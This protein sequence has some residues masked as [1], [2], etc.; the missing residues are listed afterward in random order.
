MDPKEHQPK[1]PAPKMWETEKVSV[2]KQSLANERRISKKL[3]FKL[4]PGSGN[5]AWPS[6]KGDGTTDE[7]VFELKETIRDRFTITPEVLAKLWREAGTAGKHPALV[8]SM[9]G[10]EE[11]VPKE[12]VAVPMEV[13]NEM[14]EQK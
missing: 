9:Y 10:L 11:P 7:F 4:T 1:K 12:W 8:I 14:K 5:Q 13:F 2:K 6:R 3:G